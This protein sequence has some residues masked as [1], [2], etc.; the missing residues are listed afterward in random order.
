M[1]GAARASTNVTLRASIADDRAPARANPSPAKFDTRFAAARPCQAVL[2]GMPQW[3]LRPIVAS[4]S[5]IALF[6][7]APG[8]TA[9]TDD[10][11]LTPWFPD[12]GQ[13]GWSDIHAGC[14]RGCWRRP[15][16]IADPPKPVGGVLFKRARLDESI[17]A[18]GLS[19]RVLLPPFVAALAFLLRQ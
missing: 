3:R 5:P 14:G 6:R 8:L 16:V 9:P 13:L 7:G 10:A 19:L 2:G 1:T 11:A 4:L 15:D 17:G 18:G 12:L